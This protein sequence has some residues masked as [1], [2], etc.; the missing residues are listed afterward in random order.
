[1][2]TIAIATNQRRIAAPSF[3]RAPRPRSADAAS[4]TFVASQS[5]TCNTWV[6]A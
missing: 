6:A 3:T 5:R 4:E 2:R 1:L